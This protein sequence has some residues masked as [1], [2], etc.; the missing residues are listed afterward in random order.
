MK[1]TDCQPIQIFFA[2]VAENLSYHVAL[3][4]N[5]GIQYQ[6]ALGKLALDLSDEIEEDEIFPHRIPRGK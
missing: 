5:H 1:K 3:N 4:G 2:K 6:Q